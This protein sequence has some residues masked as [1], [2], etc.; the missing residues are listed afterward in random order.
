MGACWVEVTRRSERSEHEERMAEGWLILCAL[1]PRRVAADEEDTRPGFTV[2]GWD[3]DGGSQSRRLQKVS[4]QSM[5][6]RQ[7]PTTER[8]G[9][10]KAPKTRKGWKQQTKNQTERK[11]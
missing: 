11:H 6:A 10:E 1:E 2:Q 3:R 4:A 7:A 8:R 5:V 9:Q